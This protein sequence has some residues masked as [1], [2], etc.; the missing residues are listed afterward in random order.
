MKS[1]LYEE[2]KEMMMEE[3]EAGS[4]LSGHKQVAVVLDWLT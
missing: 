4:N 1:K 3:I 2:S